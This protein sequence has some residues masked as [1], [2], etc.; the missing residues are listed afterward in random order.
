[1]AHEVETGAAPGSAQHSGPSVTS[2]VTGI[3]NDAQEL[4]KQ[5]VAMLRHEIKEDF[6]KTKDATLALGVGAGVALLGMILLCLMVVYLLHEVGGLHLWVSYL[7]VG[8]VLTIVGGVLIYLGKKKFDSFNPLP[9][10]TAQALKENVEWI[11]KP[12]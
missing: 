12:K 3:I 11:T 4:I 5:Q 9:H 1:M 6:R 8:G 10:E 2:L 7:I